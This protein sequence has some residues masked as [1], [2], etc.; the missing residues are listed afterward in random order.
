MLLVILRIIIIIIFIFET[1]YY[2]VAQA[3]LKLVILLP[4]PP[5]Y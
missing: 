3:G 5:E 4:Q 2:F 1:G